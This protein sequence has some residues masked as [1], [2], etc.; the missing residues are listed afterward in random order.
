MGCVYNQYRHANFR[1]FV[2]FSRVTQLPNLPKVV[3]QDSNPA[4]TKV[5]LDRAIGVYR[6][7]Q[8]K[9][10]L[11]TLNPFFWAGILLD[12][13]VN[14][15]FKFLGKSGLNTKAIE[16]S[17]LGKIFKFML[18]IVSLIGGIITIAQS[19]GFLDKLKLFLRL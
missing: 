13:V 15:P 11:R 17:F 6:R 1:C 19:I 16:E 4:A 5:I 18:Y 8:N 7:D 9:S 12:L 3:E 10:I 2:L 14:V